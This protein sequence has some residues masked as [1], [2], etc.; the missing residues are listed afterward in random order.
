MDLRAQI[1]ETLGLVTGT[2]VTLDVDDTPGI[3]VTTV[4]PIDGEPV[5]LE[6]VPHSVRSAGY[7]VLAQIASG[8]L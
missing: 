1:F 3:P 7:Q 6:L 2:L 4:V 8:E 5:T